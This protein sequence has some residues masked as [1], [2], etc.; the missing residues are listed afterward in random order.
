MNKQEKV[1]ILEEHLPYEIMM[2]RYAFDQ[3]QTLER[4]LLANA[5]IETYCLHARNLIDFFWADASPKGRTPTAN[6]FTTRDYLKVRGPDV[7]R[8]DLYAEL[9]HQIAHLS[10]NRTRNHREKIDGR[11][12]AILLQAIEAAVSEFG[13]HLRDEYKQYWRAR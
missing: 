3:L 2:L 13:Q 7:R 11:D 8:G 12:R 1:D 5:F 10:Y 4:G 6:H 9:N